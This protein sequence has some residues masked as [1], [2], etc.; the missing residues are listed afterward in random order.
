MILE[1]K[2]QE[3]PLVSVIIPSFNYGKYLPE[4][5]ESVAIQDYPNIE[6]VVVDD[7]STDDTREICQRYPRV[8]Y[9]HQTNQG[10]S[11]ARNFGIKNSAGEYIIFLDADDWL[12]PGAVSRNV[13]HLLERPECVFVSGG[14]EVRFTR[15]GKIYNAVEHVASGHYARLLQGN[16]VGVPATALYRRRVF[17]EFV[18]DTDIKSC[19]D[20]DLYLRITRKYPVHHHSEK[21]AAYRIHHNNMSSNV[22]AML[23]ES[24]EVL[25][26]QQT[27]LRGE[28]ELKAFRNGRKIW[29]DWYCHELYKSMCFGNAPVSLAN[30]AFILKNSPATLLLFF[31]S[32]I[33]HA[34]ILGFG[35]FEFLGAK[36][37][38][39]GD[40][41]AAKVR[42]LK[43]PFYL[44]NNT[45][46]IP[47]F[48]ELFFSDGARNLNLD[49]D[50]K[51]IVDCEAGIGLESIDLAN[52]YPDALIYALEPHPE[53]YELLVKNAVNY[54]NIRCLN[55][56]FASTTAKLK[57]TASGA[58]VWF[59]YA[60]PASHD[61]GDAVDA[62]SVADFMKME[63]LRQI[64]LF[65]INLRGGEKD[66][67]TE[68]YENWLSSTRAIIIDPHDRM[69]AGASKAF[70]GAL[71]G[72]DFTVHTFRDYLV[73]AIKN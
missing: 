22:P 33:Q 27:S 28:E 40:L 29:K 24:L 37:S 54:P 64:D 66:L 52:R 13:R 23:D 59:S 39:G 36:R 68:N 14:Y 12:L 1:K 34:R 41:I 72:H 18:F 56:T 60:R 46:D 69:R 10:L 67:F 5:F 26:R 61:D 15:T 47:Q 3:Q 73:C 17:D 32:M 31:N 8:K 2:M 11:A 42:W 65:K 25:K 51:I 57:M 9:F 58:D 70:F 63:S 7:G 20:Y 71:A 55:L 48:Y 16:Y 4:A 35:V 44:R 38:R 45:A 50:P 30:L 53:N 19:Q 43:H 62:V 21:V 49:I 6:I